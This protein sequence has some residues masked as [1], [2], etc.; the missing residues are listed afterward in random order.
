[1]G[2]RGGRR[3][4]RAPALTW[5]GTRTVSERRYFLC[6][7]D[8]FPPD[9]RPHLPHAVSRPV[10]EISRKFERRPLAVL[11]GYGSRRSPERTHVRANIAAIFSIYTSETDPEN[12]KGACSSTGTD[13]GMGENGI[14]IR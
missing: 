5:T 2:I 7:R 4:G 12:G 10:L 6:D 1:M 11:E 14:C 3:E 8:V 13:I 9:L